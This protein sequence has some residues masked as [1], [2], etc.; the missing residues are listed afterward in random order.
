M[1]EWGIAE[2]VIVIGGIILVLVSGM[3]VG[4]AIWVTKVQNEAQA[5]AAEKEAA[6]REKQKRISDGRY[7]KVTFIDA[8]GESEDG[9]RNG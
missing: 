3:A 9:T 1:S 7:D 5:K 4:A 8:A 2:W 6:E